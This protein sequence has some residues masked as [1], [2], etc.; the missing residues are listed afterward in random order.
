L[1]GAFTLFNH[2]SSLSFDVAN[3]PDSLLAVVTLAKTDTVDC[4]VYWLVNNRLFYGLGKTVFAMKTVLRWVAV[5]P[6]AVAA[7]VAVQLLNILFGMFFPAF[8]IQLWNCWIGTAVFVFAGCYT[9]PRFKFAVGITLS[10]IMA[11]LLGIY[12]FLGPENHSWFYFLLM[13]AISLAALVYACVIV[14]CWE[15]ETDENQLAMNRKN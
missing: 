2:Y 4:R 8:V 13:A 5:L 14:K 1:A 10:L 9:A 12:L 15:T 6:A 11:M 3:W 7:S